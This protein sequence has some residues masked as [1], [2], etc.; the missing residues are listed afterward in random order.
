MVPTAMAALAVFAA[1]V[2]ALDPSVVNV[3]KADIIAG[4]QPVIEAISIMH[5]VSFAVG[6]RA[7]GDAGPVSVQFGLDDRAAGT[8]LLASS[9]FPLGSVTK[10]WTATA[11]MRLHERGLIDIDAPISTYVD[12]LLQRENGTTMLELWGGDATV[13]NVTAR[14]LMSMRAGMN[15]Y[16][17]DAYRAFVFAA[18]GYVCSQPC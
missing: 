17:D 4:L 15:D 18:K 13:N 3:S 9:R 1:A 11:V 5:N 7:T 10:S 16:D 6:V 12:P 14:L 8:P 2:H